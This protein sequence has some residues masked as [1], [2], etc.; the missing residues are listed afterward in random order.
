[1][2]A[3]E[4]DR[5]FLGGCAGHGAL[6]VAAQHRVDARDE[7]ARIERLGEVV[8]G[9]HFQADDAIDVLALGRQHDDRH[10]SRRRRAGAGRRRG[11]PRRAA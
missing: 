9:A 1:M 5:A 3:A 7:L 8:V 6:A 10:R 4:R 2:C 11:R